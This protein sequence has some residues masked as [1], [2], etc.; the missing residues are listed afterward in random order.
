MHLAES[1]GP[2]LDST[3]NARNSTSATNPTQTAGL[4]GNAQ[5]FVT[6]SSNKILTP[7][8]TVSPVGPGSFTISGWM[9]N[10][11][12]SHYG[13][14]WDGRVSSAGGGVLLYEPISTGFGTFFMNTS[15]A[16]NVSIA[17][18][19]NLADNAWHYLVA[20][21]HAGDGACKLYV[22]GAFITS[23][24]NVQGFSSTGYIGASFDGVFGTQTIQETRWSS[25]ARSADWITAEYNNQKSGSTML[26]I[27]SPL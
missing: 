24:G 27:S 19:T 5:S 10:P 21:L 7:L 12:T 22:D 16:S 17:G 14:L 1:S 3:S 25:T 9:K 8:F 4:F 18:S 11:S 23:G 13:L 2:Y 15:G 20:G 26:T 6:A